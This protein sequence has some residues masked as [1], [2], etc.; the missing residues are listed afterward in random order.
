VSTRQPARA[1]RSRLGE[2]VFFTELMAPW[3]LTEGKLSRFTCE[4]CHFEGYV[5]G[6]THFTGRGAVYATTR[7]LLG[8]FNNRPHFSRALDRTTAQMVHAEFR[9]ANRHNGRDPWF[10][11][12]AADVGWL[13]ALAGLPATL[14]PVLLRESLIAFLADFTH[15][16]NPAALDHARFT[17]DEAAGARLFEA[18]CAPCHAARL[19][20]DDP[21][22]RVPFAR[23]EAL[24][25][26][27]AG[28][29]VWSDGAYAKTGVV[30]YVHPAGARAPTLRRLAKKWPYFTNGRARS[31]DD[32]LAAFAWT[33]AAAFHA[34]APA[35]AARLTEAE[36]AALAAFLA[37]L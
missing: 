4:T 6:R 5:D 3:N 13:G 2:L 16:A 37:L 36:R 10:A 11:V 20:A 26:S 21:A 12:S 15:R 34:D 32:V 30:P 28:P 14:S 7:P 19:V 29:I 8:L 35:A 27:P 23:W 1:L 33:G 18:R 24:I 22:T 25:L 9:V 31:L 17:D